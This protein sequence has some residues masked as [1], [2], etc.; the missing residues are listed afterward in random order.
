ML[1][2]ANGYIKLCDLGFVKSIP[3]TDKKGED[4][5][6]SF[7][8][9]G[10]PDYLPPEV[11]LTKGHEKSVDLWSLGCVVYELLFGTTPFKEDNQNKVGHTGPFLLREASHLDVGG[12]VL[13]ILQTF[14]R[15]CKRDIRW[16]EGAQEEHSLAVDLIE[17]LMRVEPSER[18]GAGH[19]GV[20]E[21]QEHPWF[22]GLDWEALEAQYV[23]DCDSERSTCADSYLRVW[24]FCSRI[25][26]PYKP[27]I[28]DPTDRSNF[29][30]YESDEEDESDEEVEYSGGQ[31]AFRD[32]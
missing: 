26:A 23:F 2:A 22:G 27:N 32:F 4:F 21:I 30:L 9:L 10:S 1:V 6:Q 7:T 11:I 15:A 12:V 8:M 5:A 19:R 29:E 18:L 31:K 17:Q 28:Q 13:C 24:C 3:Y 25:E 16:P 20:A 14:E